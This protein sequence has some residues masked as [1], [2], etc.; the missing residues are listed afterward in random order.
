LHRRSPSKEG[1]GTPPWS[2][3]KLDRWERIWHRHRTGR[4]LA[5]DLVHGSL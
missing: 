2:W 4:V 3:E 1:S 5:K